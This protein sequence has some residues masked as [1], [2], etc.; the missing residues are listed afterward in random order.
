M[1]ACA[2]GRWFAANTYGITTPAAAPT[3]PNMPSVGEL[4][5]HADTPPLVHGR[6]AARAGPLR[7]VDGGGNSDWANNT[8]EMIDSEVSD[9]KEG[10]GSA[11]AAGWELSGPLA[12][13]LDELGRHSRVG[14]IGLLRRPQQHFGFGSGCRQEQ[15]QAEKG[16]VT[17]EGELENLRLQVEGAQR[18]AE[19]AKKEA[20]D[21]DQAAK[22]AEEK[23]EAE[24]DPQKKQQAEEDAAKKRKEA[25]EAQ[26]AAQRKAAEAECRRLSG[27]SCAEWEAAKKKQAS[28]ATIIRFSE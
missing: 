26:A 1:V 24:T 11:V 16:R 8:I 9:C 25:E 6:P 20:D 22:A 13:A 2:D 7:E 17:A 4:V 23:A 27:M 28:A 12:D 21:A 19:I 18:D 14:T 5:I 3:Q 15:Q 10:P